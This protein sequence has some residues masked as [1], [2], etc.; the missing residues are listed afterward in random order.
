MVH[1]Y[2]DMAHIVPLRSCASTLNQVFELACAMQAYFPQQEA[3]CIEIACT[4]MLEVERSV[5]DGVGFEGRGQLPKRGEAIMVDHHI[6]LQENCPARTE[7][8]I[9]KVKVLGR[10]QWT[11]AA[12]HLVEPSELLADGSAHRKVGAH[13]EDLKPNAL[14]EPLPLRN[15]QRG[16]YA[17]TLHA[18]HIGWREHLPINQRHIG[19][20]VK[21]ARDC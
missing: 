8:P 14:V 16:N 7:H 1:A 10:L 21:A 19:L 3:S 17:I 4:H 6:R 9:G 11:A 12:K 13:A 15:E 18:R 20:L 5:S 2:E